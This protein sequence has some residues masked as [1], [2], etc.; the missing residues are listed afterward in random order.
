[1]KKKKQLINQKKAL[2]DRQLFLKKAFKNLKEITN[3]YDNWI[4]S[5]EFIEILD[6]KFDEFLD[7]IYKARYFTYLS[8]GS[9]LENVSPDV[10]FSE[11]MFLDLV[12]TLYSMAQYIDRFIRHQKLLRKMKENVNPGNVKL[13]RYLLQI[14]ETDNNNILREIN[15]IQNRIDIFNR[16]MDLM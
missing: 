7:N 1:M 10:S 11:I 4:K 5:P 15:T 12:E 3:S 13:M 16:V 6:E 9:D 2:Q 8:I 14:I